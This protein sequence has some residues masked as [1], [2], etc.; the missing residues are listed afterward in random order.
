MTSPRPDDDV[1][2]W[3][4][5][6]HPRLFFPA[7][8]VRVRVE[9]IQFQLPSFILAMHSSKFRRELASRAP[10]AAAVE[11]IVIRDL[12]AI[13]F[14]RMVSVLLPSVPGQLELT[15]IEEW[16]SVLHVAHTWEFPRIKTLALSQIE[17]IASAVDKVVI[18]R[19]HDL[20]RWTAAG[21][22]V[23]CQRADPISKDEGR[24]LGV[25]IVTD[26][27]ILRHSLHG[28]SGI[29]VDEE[30]VRGLLMPSLPDTLQDNFVACLLRTSLFGPGNTS[31]GSQLG[32]P[33]DQSEESQTGDEESE[34]E[35]ESR[36]SVSSLGDHDPSARELVR[37]KSRLFRSGKV[38]YTSLL[39][40]SS[41]NPELSFASSLLFFSNGTKR[42]W[43]ISLTFGKLRAGSPEVPSTP[44]S[45]SSLSSDTSSPM[46]SKRPL[47]DDIDAWSTGAGHSFD[48]R[49]PIPALS[50]QPHERFF[51]SSDFV[52]L[53]I[54]SALFHLPSFLLC[55]HSDRFRRL[56]A[57]RAPG[58]AIEQIAIQDIHAIG[59]ERLLSI[60]I[61]TVPGK[62]EL[63]SVEEWT[64]VLDV[65]HTWEFR[66]IEALTL[67]QIEP[68]A[69]AV[70]KVVLGREHDLP[71]WTAAGYMELCQRKEP[72]SRVE[73]RRLGVDIV[74]DI[75]IIRHYVHG[76]S[77][78]K[79]VDEEP[80]REVIMSSLRYTLRNNLVACLLK[81]SLFCAHKPEGSQRGGLGEGSNRG[82]EPD[83]QYAESDSSI[84]TI[85]Q[86]QD[87]PSRTS[88]P[89]S[90]ISHIDKPSP[91]SF[92]GKA[93]AAMDHLDL[94][95]PPSPIVSPP[96]DT[97]SST[98]GEILFV[99]APKLPSSSFKAKKKNLFC[100]SAMQLTEIE[101]DV[102][103]PT[104]PEIKTMQDGAK[105]NSLDRHP[106]QLNPGKPHGEFFFQNDFVV[107]RVE[108]TLFN[109][110]TFMLSQ[111]S[112]KFERL[113]LSRASS[114]VNVETIQLKDTKALD[115]ERLLTVL[116]PS[117]L[118]QSRL[119]TVEEWTSVLSVAH[120]WEFSAIKKLAIDRLEPIAS[121]V[122]RVVLGQE[123]DLPDWTSAGYME[124]CRRENPISKA[125]G[126]R[127]GFDASIDI[128]SIRHHLRSRGEITNDS[129][130]QSLCSGS[131]HLL[132]GNC[133]APYL[134]RSFPVPPRSYKGAKDHR[135]SKI[136]NT[137]G[138]GTVDDPQTKETKEH[139]PDIPTQ[140]QVSCASVETQETPEKNSDSSV[141][142]WDFGGWG[143]K[144]A[145]ASGQGA[146]PVVATPQKKGGVMLKRSTDLEFSREA[147]GK[148]VRGY[149][150]LEIWVEVEYLV[151]LIHHVVCNKDPG[152]SLCLLSGKILNFGL[153]SATFWPSNPQVRTE[154]APKWL[155]SR[156]AG[157][158]GRF[159]ST[160]S[161]PGLE[162]GAGQA[163][164]D[165][166][167]SF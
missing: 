82:G 19:E 134:E 155:F 98:S 162:D 137:T 25:D 49:R 149:N 104:Q 64:S 138:N 119:S 60:L 23:L 135:R 109:L 126:H 70:D 163:R 117:V 84:S 120:N 147:H 115:F 161:A 81:D 30:S 68:I 140:L 22:L 41:L 133:V 40:I 78:G 106:S 129:T 55:M 53:R 58:T 57:S 66:T 71:Q 96:S 56:L 107:L 34:E 152:S 32:D 143:S 85:D 65:A 12:K 21:C 76:K 123:Y 86:K 27:S 69:S 167:L 31:E 63:T 9:R 150:P 18:G 94:S 131:R 156:P 154:V 139:T 100:S 93:P 164:G 59:F 3:N 111:H 62:L 29:R 92:R 24:R 130:I 148:T 166:V 74:T 95:S 79:R 99:P 17:P 91:P 45:F 28:A 125:E 102:T 90:Y 42:Y 73:G 26:I 54:E 121:A 80:V 13:D 97:D 118:G 128:S 43:I 113:L 144:P 16:I 47:D 4:T 88:T 72:I 108:S 160:T 38:A 14:E 44:L 142:K 20:P 132:D 153:K 6:R 146:K 116:F 151:F 158:C 101:T 61:P 77:G 2:A 103:S 7:D 124:L 50:A 11:E 141:G 165:A 122:D 110:P 36:G 1:D 157:P 105:Q 37:P 89:L 15:S 67:A 114:E 83:T 39:T 145:A 5:R 48:R 33:S 10:G 52:T 87:V 46:T 112:T 51:L 8:F 35:D 127:I 136:A 159:W 75:S